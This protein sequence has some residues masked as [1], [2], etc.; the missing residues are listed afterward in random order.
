MLDLSARSVDQSTA[1]MSHMKVVGEV[2]AGGLT[3][4]AARGLDVHA[5][6]HT[7]ARRPAP[8]GNARRK[9][10]V[11]ACLA[12]APRRACLTLS[13]GVGAS[14]LVYPDVLELV[15]QYVASVRG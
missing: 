15:I 11:G 4:G 10:K 5:R 3:S 12:T 14:A 8:D 9:M 13:P 6:V 2:A 1:I 7:T